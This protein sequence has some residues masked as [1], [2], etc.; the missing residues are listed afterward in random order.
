MIEITKLKT[1]ESLIHHLFLIDERAAFP[2][3]QKQVDLPSV[4]K[5]LANH[6]MLRRVGLVFL[7][8]EHAAA[9]ANYPAPVTKLCLLDRRAYGEK[10]Q[11]MEGPQ[12]AR[13]WPRSAML[14]TKGVNRSCLWNTRDTRSTRSD[15]KVL[16]RITRRRLSH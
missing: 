10:K 5:P 9:L 4:S 2:S 11:Q 12:P 8:A 14:Q 16:K 7:P 13:T 6:P 3:T 1:R 15:G